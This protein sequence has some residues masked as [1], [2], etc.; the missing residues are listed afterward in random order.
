[1]KYQTFP[2]VSLFATFPVLAFDLGFSSELSGSAGFFGSMMT[3][4]RLEA[5]PLEAGFI[6]KDASLTDLIAGITSTR[7]VSKPQQTQQVAL[8]L[9]GISAQVAR[10]TSGQQSLFFKHSE[11]SGKV[12]PESSQQSAS[13]Y[14]SL[15]LKIAEPVANNKLKVL[16][17]ETSSSFVLSSTAETAHRI[18]V[19][20]RVDKEGYPEGVLTGFTMLH[21]TSLKDMTSAW[22]CYGNNAG[23]FFNSA[24][25][26]AFYST[27]YSTI[28]CDD[29][30]H[31]SWNKEENLYSYHA[32][33]AAPSP[34]PPDFSFSLQQFGYDE[35][36][37]LS[38]EYLLLTFK[39]KPTRVS[40]IGDVGSEGKP[41]DGNAFSGNG[42]AGSGHSYSAT[43]SNTA[44]SSSSQAARRNSVHSGSAGAGAGGNKPPRRPVKYEK[45]EPE[46]GVVSDKTKQKQ[47]H[48]EKI[49]EDPEVAT[50]FP[51]SPN[52]KHPLH[53]GAVNKKGK[54]P[55]I[56]KQIIAR[57]EM[58]N[59]RLLNAKKSIQDSMQMI[60]DQLASKHLQA[61]H[62]SIQSA[63]E[64]LFP[65]SLPSKA[66]TP[67]RRS[68]QSYPATD[69]SEDSQ[70]ED[71]DTADEN[72]ALPNSKESSITK[73]QKRQKRN[74]KP[75]ID[76]KDDR[77][78]KDG[79]NHKRTNKDRIRTEEYRAAEETE[80]FP[81]AVNN[82]T[83]ENVGQLESQP[84][85]ELQGETKQTQG[86]G[87]IELNLNDDNEFPRL[88]EDAS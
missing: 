64:Q 88:V 45:K 30:S 7:I 1:M 52:L 51:S 35:G 77:S 16:L 21:H 25:Y 56:R 49:P 76:S 48:R 62:D 24:F 75:K 38:Y 83:E 72:T 13:D 18:K 58:L 33:A 47:K 32:V 46:D 39:G 86:G 41:N 74:Q 54:Q 19:P 31:L 40:A 11:K 80:D 61:A 29:G 67:S 42:A 37:P 26:S 69:Y 65:S 82:E 68:S 55:I 2:M 4:A 12:L 71:F 70:Q 3:S 50:F 63:T 9:F 17:D 5:P 78:N 73:R 87:T 79:K 53:A 27:F 23:Y 22:F 10:D 66:L 20:S 34:T 43:S 28:A 85:S 14:Q 59:E 60:S 8:P 6:R 36:W 15:L 84:E 57:D 44:Q 81:A